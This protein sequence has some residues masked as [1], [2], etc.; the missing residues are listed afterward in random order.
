M[1]QINL[2]SYMTFTDSRRKRIRILNRLESINQ[3]LKKRIRVD[4]FIQQIFISIDVKS[5]ICL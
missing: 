4:A 2:L 3:E 5:N 1:G